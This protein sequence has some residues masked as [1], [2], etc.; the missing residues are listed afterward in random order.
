MMATGPAT[1]T[2]RVVDIQPTVNTF[3]A[4]SVIKPQRLSPP[5]CKKTAEFGIMPFK[6]TIPRTL[7][8]ESHL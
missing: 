3:E 7:P 1:Y 2:P 4:F 6:D 5:N 8:L